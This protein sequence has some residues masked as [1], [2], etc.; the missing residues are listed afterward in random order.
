MSKIVG[1][2]RFGKLHSGLDDSLNLARICIELNKMD[3]NFSKY[4]KNAIPM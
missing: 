3:I 4:V 1:I 2:S